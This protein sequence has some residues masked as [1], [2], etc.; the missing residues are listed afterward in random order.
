MS[1][2][3]ERPSMDDGSMEIT[4]DELR[5][6][7]EAD[8]RGVRADPGFK[9]RLRRRLWDIVRLRGD[10]SVGGGEEH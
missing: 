5:E 6:F 10:P 4:M 1:A 2:K 3:T 7:L 9:E 8:D